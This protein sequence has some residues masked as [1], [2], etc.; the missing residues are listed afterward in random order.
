[1]EKALAEIL[2]PWARALVLGITATSIENELK[3]ACIGAK[4]HSH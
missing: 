1:M 2:A 4:V 3:W